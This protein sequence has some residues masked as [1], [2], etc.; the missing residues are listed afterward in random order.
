MK[1]LTLE[2]CPLDF[3]RAVCWL[4]EFDPPKDYIRE[5]PVRG[6]GIC[7]TCHVSLSDPAFQPY[8]AVTDTHRGC[9]LAV[10]HAPFCPGVCP[11]LHKCVLL[12]VYKRSFVSINNLKNSGVKHEA[13][14]K[15]LVCYMK[16]QE[17]EQKQEEERRQRRQRQQIQVQQRLV[18]GN[19]LKSMFDRYQEVQFGPSF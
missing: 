16:R 13:E 9:S 3:Q 2:K 15:K 14:I 5:D 19:R 7:K 18:A 17:R 4:D 12:K 10:S 11:G 6:R 1:R 8:G